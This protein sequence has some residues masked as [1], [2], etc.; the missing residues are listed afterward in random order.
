MFP[1]TASF[2]VS[3]EEKK[4]KK[5]ERKALLICLLSQGWGIFANLKIGVIFVCLFWLRNICLYTVIR[6]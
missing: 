5:K 2:I 6:H 4:K 1:E 3:N